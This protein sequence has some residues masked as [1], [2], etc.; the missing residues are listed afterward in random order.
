MKMLSCESRRQIDPVYGF[1]TLRFGHK[2]AFLSELCRIRNICRFA[3]STASRE[4]CILQ[5]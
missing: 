1:V 3:R 5:H 2:R 4:P